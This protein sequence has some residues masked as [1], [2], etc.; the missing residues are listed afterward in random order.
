M[1]NVKGIVE[2]ITKDQVITSVDFDETSNIVLADNISVGAEL[3]DVLD[4]SPFYISYTDD[5]EI[6]VKYQYDDGI[7]YHL[8][9]DKNNK[10]H[11]GIISY[12]N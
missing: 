2:E 1:F 9:F 4:T 12:E 3:K 10:L 11:H 7:V 5:E 8:S 6:Y